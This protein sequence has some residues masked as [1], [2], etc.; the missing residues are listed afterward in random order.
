MN[1]ADPGEILVMS[2]GAYGRRIA[3]FIVTTVVVIWGT[4][5]AVRF[6]FASPWNLAY[7]VP[8]AFIANAIGVNTAYHMY[9]THG[10]FQA[11]APFRVVL[12]V[13]GT[14][15][16][17]D[18][19]IQWVANHKRHHRHVDVPDRD[20]HTPWQFGESKWR[21]YTVGL[22]W[23]SVGWKYA[24]RSTSKTFYAGSLL[25]DPVLRFFDKHFVVVSYL[26]LVVPFAVGYALGGW[27]AG[28]KG[29]AYFGAFR[30]FV[31]YAFTELVINGFCHC[32]GSRKF[33]TKGLAT[34]IPS[35]AM[36]S[37]GTT[38]HHNHHAFPQSLSTAV[39]GE[40]DPMQWINGF[41]AKCGW[42]SSAVHP[43]AAEVAAKKL[44]EAI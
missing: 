6:M 43:S 14:I 33:A 26:G 25:K 34:N 9:F 38:L 10:A 27:Q 4:V 44:A 36:L 29:F 31:G 22:L 23:A 20:P 15:L 32:V 40:T 7:V 17:Q 13:F 28:L 19:L 5:L 2:R 11:K 41:F 42:I 12:A 3:Y 1:F 18:S 8:I 37:M 21:V 39:D 16:C 30:V 24:R 35:L